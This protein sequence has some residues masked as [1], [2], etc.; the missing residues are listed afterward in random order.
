MF[1][2]AGISLD[3]ADTIA[4]RC[5]GFSKVR[6]FYSDSPDDKAIQ[7]IQGGLLVSIFFQLMVRLRTEWQVVFRPLG[8]ATITP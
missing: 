2:G 7:Y 5:T 8:C 4:A 1:F 6:K 3:T